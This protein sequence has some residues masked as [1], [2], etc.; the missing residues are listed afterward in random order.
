MS[1][2]IRLHPYLGCQNMYLSLPV[3]M[4]QH[5]GMQRMNTVIKRIHEEVQQELPAGVISGEFQ[6]TVRERILPALKADGFQFVDWTGCL[7]R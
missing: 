6:S 2:L 1:R 5:E 3:G 4:T 7:A